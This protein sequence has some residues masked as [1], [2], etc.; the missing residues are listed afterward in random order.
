[1]AVTGD[2]GGRDL[3]L[4]FSVPGFAAPVSGKFPWEVPKEG[5]SSSPGKGGVGIAAGFVVWNHLPSSSW[6]AQDFGKSELVVG[7]VRREA[8]NGNSGFWKVPAKA[9]AK[10]NTSNLHQSGPGTKAE[11]ARGSSRSIPG[12]P[13][14]PRPAGK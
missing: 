14:R 4:P 6:D 7:A 12:A 8:G 13:A 1:M 9:G 10:E 3:P 2:D 11:P 5:V